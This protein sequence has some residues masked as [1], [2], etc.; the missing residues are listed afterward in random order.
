MS[1]LRAIEN[2]VPIVRPAAAGT[3]TAI[4]ATGRLVGSSSFQAE[5]D[6]VLRTEIGIGSIPSLYTR[7]GDAFGWLTFML[8]LV[9]SLAATPWR[10]RVQ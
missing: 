5:G 1:R 9:L 7:V 6:N 2:G 8:L 10:R 4:D 3:T